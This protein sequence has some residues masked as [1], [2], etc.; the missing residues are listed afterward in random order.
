[1]SKRVRKWII[2]IGIGI[3]LIV[4]LALVFNEPIKNWVISNMTQNHIEQLTKKKVTANAKKKTTFNFK[5]VKSLG[6]NEVAHAAVN[7]DGV[8]TIGKMAIPS[9]D[10]RLPI[11]KGLSNDALATGGATMK[12]DQKM[13]QGNYA[14]AGHYMLNNG[15]NLFSP[16]DNI[17]MG[18][19]MYITDL[20]KV[21][22]YKVTFKKV[23]NPYAT[24]LI[25]DVPGKKLL[26]LI[27]CA[28]G[29]V[30]RLA[31]QGKLTATTKATKTN[32][33]VFNK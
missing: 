2:N 26:T 5:Q 25:D 17:Q 11:V 18:A 22:Q 10:M 27:T 12:E 24:E 20:T 4:G 6:V 3:L 21:Y 9:I 15:A 16:L 29:G 23:V 31:V 19:T 28:D 30:N 14:L 7:Q 8:L 33:V 1:M 32:L 13:G